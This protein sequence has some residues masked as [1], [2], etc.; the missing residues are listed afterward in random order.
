MDNKKIEIAVQQVIR[1]CG[2]YCDP[3][4]YALFRVDRRAIKGDMASAKYWLAIAT[5]IKVFGNKHH[6]K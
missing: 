3:R 5:A 6:E 2:K 4:Q 1:K